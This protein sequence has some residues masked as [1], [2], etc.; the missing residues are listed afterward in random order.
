MESFLSPKKGVAVTITYLIAIPLFYLF[1]GCQ[2]KP[3]TPEEVAKEP[4]PMVSTAPKEEAPTDWSKA[5]T[6]LGK[7]EKPSF[8]ND[9]KRLLFISRDRNA[10]KHRQLYEMNLESKQ[11]KRLTYQDGE[12]FEGTLSPDD[13]SIFYTSTTDEI[14]ERPLLFYPELKS[15]P[16]PTTEIYRIKP[17]DDLH[18]RWTQRPG[19]DG[20]IHTHTEPGK[21]LA[22]TQSRWVGSDLQMYR[23]YGQKPSFEDVGGRKSGLWNHS[24][25][26]HLKKPWKA[27]IQENSITGATTLIFQKA[28]AKQNLELP[29]YEVRD[30]QFVETGSSASDPEMVQLIYTGR[31]EKMG[32]RKAFWLNLTAKCQAPFLK[33]QAEVSGL[34]VSPDGKNLAWTLSQGDQSQ[35]FMGLLDRG[36]DTCE[37]LGKGEGA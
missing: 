33:S 20:F 10:H 17:K 19:F 21:G 34:Q 15:E 16:F 4:L 11:E 12:V 14:K 13:Q 3:T 9:G 8:S 2:S 37:P 1:V 23:S 5:I 22:V 18:E 32:Q 31:S 30:L 26:T 28:G 24:F 29:T 27:W 6:K 36:S 7:N 25:T 35:I